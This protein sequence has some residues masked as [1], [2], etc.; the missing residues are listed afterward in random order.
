MLEKKSFEQ[1]FHEHRGNVIHK[2]QNYFEVYDKHFSRY[3]DKKVT[4]LEIGVFKGGSLDLWKKYFGPQCEIIGVDINPLCKRFEDERTK[5]FI[6]SQDDRE[7]LRN[8][9]KEIPRVDVFIDDGGHMMDQLKITFEEMYDWV[10][11]DGVYLAEDLHTSYWTDYGGGYHRPNTFIEYC[12]NLVD[13]LNAWHSTQ[14]KFQ[15][16]GFTKT[17]HSIHFYDSIVV[18]EK[19]KMTRP[20]DLYAGDFQQEDIDAPPPSI[21]NPWKNLLNKAY[22]ITGIARDKLSSRNNS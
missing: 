20:V 2:W 1:L 22:R 6:G 11:D 8:L 15:V 14:K 9:K 7:F 5:I 16:D 3:R 4:V 21:K 10:A 19:K 12:K 13:Q 18:F 17:T